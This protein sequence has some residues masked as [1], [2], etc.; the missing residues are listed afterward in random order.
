MDILKIFKLIPVL[1]VLLVLASCS[2]SD[3]GNSAT[4]GRVSLLIT[5]GVTED[6]DE[7]NLTVESISFLGEDDGHETIV[8]N[9]P[10][11]VNLLALQH[12][13]DLLVTTIISVGT[14]DKIR[15]H[16]S[17]VE[18]VKEGQEPI[19]TRL[20]A[21]GKVDLNP[22]GTFEVVGDGH[23]MIELDIDA[24]KSIHIVQQG[25]GRAV[26]NF[27]PV[28]FV[29]IVGV[30]DSKLVLLENRRV[31]ARTETGFQLCDV[32]VLE[33]DDSCLAVLLSGNTV[34]QNDLIEVVASDSIENDDI[35]TLLGTLGSEYIDALHIV[36]ASDDIEEQNLALFKG[37]AVSDVIPAVGGNEFGM[38]TIVQP[39]TVSLL[40]GSGVR[41]FDKYGVEVGTDAIVAM[42]TGVVVFGLKQFDGLASV[43]GV[44]AAFV[45]IDNDAK[46]DKI[47]G[48]IAAINDVDSEITV[49]V[50]N[51]IFSGDVCVD[52]NEAL[53]FQLGVMDG[54]VVIQEISISELGV[55]MT[56]D[57]YGQDNGL[58]CV[59]ADVVL[60]A[61]PLAVPLGATLL[62]TGN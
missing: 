20:P 42:D 16:V 40:D 7:V 6:F 21:N 33:V 48:I 61:D 22:R 55:G 49:A 43:I 45:I 30:D 54:K 10:R 38:Q 56:A 4:T 41:I 9:E 62:V 12:Y 35:I 15:L 2:S 19:I 46:T 52:V 23:L 5:D 14:Y 24:E 26:Y 58:G 17:K 57:V 60:V 31:L 11:V 50:I 51:E 34:V 3:G 27:R 59:A 37:K 53:M 25:N 18:L 36:I 47:S 8:F 32:E 29:N 1:C 44:T 28:V 13:S 39:L